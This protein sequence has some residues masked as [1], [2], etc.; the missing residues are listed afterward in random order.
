MKW[1]RQGQNEYHHQHH[2]HRHHPHHHHHH[3]PHHH[4]HHHHLHHHHHH[5][6]H[7]HHHLYHHHH[8]SFILTSGITPLIASP[9]LAF[10]MM[11]SISAI[12][13]TLLLILSLCLANNNYKMI[14]WKFIIIYLSNILLFLQLLS[15][16][17][18][19]YNFYHHHNHHHNHH[20]YDDDVV[21]VVW[22]WW[23]SSSS[24]SLLLSSSSSFQN[25][26]I[27]TYL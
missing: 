26:S 24:T 9:S 20:K 12:A 18:Q 1:T 3:H 23:C 4:L 5:L 19:N 21:V 17:H 25:S 6:H 10:A 2:L 14:K 7:H 22:W 11:T 15:I 16:N 8:Q 13:R 27:P